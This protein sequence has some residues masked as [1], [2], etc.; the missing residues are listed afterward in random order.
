MNDQYWM[1]KAYEQAILAQTEG[2]I[3]VGAVLVNKENQLLGA[4]RNL[5]QK[6]HDPSGHA[7]IHA[8]R[9][10]SQLI[11]NHRLLDTTLYVTLEPCAMCAGL[12]VHAR[13]RRLVFATR[14][15]KSGAAGSVYN[16]LQGY[17]LN[18]KVQV[19]EGIMQTQCASL[20]T[21]F[22]KTCR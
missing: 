8:I 21:E 6:S 4:G 7:E 18:H 13:I 2:E 9:Q 14:D 1:R 10:A 15:F 12:I 17:P 22:F 5:I 16:L 20:L 3:P 11:Q 19:D